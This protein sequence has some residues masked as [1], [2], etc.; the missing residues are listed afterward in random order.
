MAALYE[1]DIWEIARVCETPG[2]LIGPRAKRACETFAR[3]VPEDKAECCRLALKRLSLHDSAGAA[4]ALRAC[5]VDHP[6]LYEIVQTRLSLWCELSPRHHMETVHML[7]VA[8]TPS[9]SSADLVFRDFMRYTP[10]TEI[11][12]VYRPS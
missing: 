10:P 9:L 8:F 3:I 6:D 12:R 2:L 4:A 11:P 1:K 7:P 5:G